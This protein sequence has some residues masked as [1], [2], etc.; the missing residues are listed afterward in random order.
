METEIK[1]VIVCGIGAIGSIY[2]DKIHSKTPNN[3]RVLVD[4]QRKIKYLKNP[5]IFNGKELNFNYIL[6]EDNDFKADLI[7]IATK[8]NGLNDAI[9]N[10]KNFVKED[11]IILSLL[12]GVSSEDKIAEVY[13]WDKVLLAFFLG[14]S[15]I[16]EGRNIIHD[17]NNTIYFGEKFSE[18]NL[19]KK[20]IRLKNYFDK[21]GIN[22]KIPSDMHYS[23]WLKFML[24]VT[25][26]QASA[27][28]KMTFGD[29]SKN[30][31]FQKFA[32]HIM[33]EVA[34]IAK[35]EGV[36]NAYK[37]IPDTAD[38]FKTMLPEGKTSMLQDVEAGRQTEV[39]IFAGTIVELGKK[40]NIP[41]PYN[42]IMMEMIEII[43]ENQ[44]IKNREL[45]LV[46]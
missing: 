22:Y 10:M 32:L 8:N 6:P 13:G 14:H 9:N 39:D 28:L 19:S 15:A 29:M 26:N 43:H 2:A 34:E 33:Q 17:D 40:H 35:A 46:H 3:L 41:T 24:N 31:K 12:N 7:I 21:I 37:L 30:S 27:I 11:T 38:L 18:N 25:G 5:I 1:N 36:P 45:S 20:T 16:R 4:E 44:I 23:Q 42:K